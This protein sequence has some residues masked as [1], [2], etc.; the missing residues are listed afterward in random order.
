MEVIKT[1]VNTCEVEAPKKKGICWYYQFGQP[2]GQD[3]KFGKKCTKTHSKICVNYP[4]SCLYGDQCRF[5]HRTP[6]A[7]FIATVQSAIKSD[8]PCRNMIENGSCKFG[9]KCNFNHNM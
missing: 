5:A 1:I 2:S 3:C 6:E 9:D 7:V 4:M 8:K